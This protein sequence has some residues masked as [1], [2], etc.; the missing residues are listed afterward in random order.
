M[1]GEEEVMA[2]EE[3]EIALAVVPT[4]AEVKVVAGELVAV[5]TKVEGFPDRKQA[6]VVEGVVRILILGKVH[7]F[8]LRLGLR[9][10]PIKPSSQS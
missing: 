5:V 7:R 2:V 3:E 1:E 4:M 10:C 9:P 6:V 8:R